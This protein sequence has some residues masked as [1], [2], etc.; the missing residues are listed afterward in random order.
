MEYK[1]LIKKLSTSEGEEASKI[2]KELGQFLN[3]STPGQRTT[4]SSECVNAIP[5]AN[6]KRKGSLC[7][8]TALANANREIIVNMLGDSSPI[9]REQTIKG[10]LHQG[11]Q[12]LDELEK[13]LSEETLYRIKKWILLTIGNVGT[14]KAIQIIK[15]NE[16]EPQIF[17]T[18][19]KILAQFK[20]TKKFKEKVTGRGGAMLIQTVAGAE[21]Q[22]LTAHG[23][24]GVR[25]GKGILQLDDEF[26]FDEFAN[27]RSIFYYGVF[28]GTISEV[29]N[30]LKTRFGTKEGYCIQYTNEI[31]GEKERLSEFQSKLA[32]QGWEYNSNSPLILK[33]LNEEEG[34]LLIKPLIKENLEYLPASI[35][36]VVGNVVNLIAE[37]EHGKANIILD[38][39]CGAST[40]LCEGKEIFNPTKRILIDK[41]KTAIEK[42]KKNFEEYKIKGEFHNKRFQ[43]VLLVKAADLIICNPPFDIRVKGD[44][45]YNDL[46]KFI[47]RN[48]TKNMTAVIYTVKKQDLREACEN[49]KLEIIKEIRL[50][51]KKINPSVFVIKKE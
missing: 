42:S 38:P 6:E 51:L 26:E 50:N 36:R 9:I 24:T 4:F 3:K 14:I 30:V 28:L 45:D 43:E 46:M 7:F 34:M 33:L 22:W 18:K 44:F 12:Y 49:N 13:R 39:C 23:L 20:Q 2:M 5:K 32:K 40:I 16:V 25:F 21:E 31:Q 35:N 1:E 47:S 11:E 29:E 19:E 48:S 27:N 15:N 17:S 41:D 8:L 37:N 10:L